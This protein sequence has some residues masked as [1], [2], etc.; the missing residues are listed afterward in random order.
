M[1]SFQAIQGHSV[2]PA[3]DLHREMFVISLEYFVRTSVV[4]FLVP[5]CLMYTCVHDERSLLTYVFFG[6]CLR[7]GGALS[8]A[9]V[10]L[11]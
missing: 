7:T 2:L 5:S 6:E 11:S 3:F 8:L 10:A 1:S 4:V 9:M